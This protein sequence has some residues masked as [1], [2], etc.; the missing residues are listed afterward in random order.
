M[1]VN[2]EED[3]YPEGRPAADTEKGRE[4]SR[5]F[6]YLWVTGGAAA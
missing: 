2:I 5:S 1:D 4:R 6:V 3:N